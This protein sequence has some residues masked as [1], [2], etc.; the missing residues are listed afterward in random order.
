[1]ALSSLNKLSMA[2]GGNA[3]PALQH[4]GVPNATDVG[5]SHHWHLQPSLSLIDALTGVRDV[6][7]HRVLQDYRNMQHLL[8]SMQNKDCKKRG[9]SVT[10]YIQNYS[11]KSIQKRGLRGC[12]MLY[13]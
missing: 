4:T 3:D 7:M 9:L 1:M 10:V 6:C 13:I 5:Q 12:T 2:P 11:V 8:Y